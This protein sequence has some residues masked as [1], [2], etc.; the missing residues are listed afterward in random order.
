[1]CNSIMLHCDPNKGV[2]EYEVRFNPQVDSIGSRS[3]YLTQHKETLGVARTFDGVTLFLPKELSTFNLVAKNPADDSDVNIEIIFKRKKRLAEC[4][5]LYNVLFDR[6]FRIL[7]YLRVGRKCFDPTKPQLI[8]QHKLEIWPGYVKS[9]DEMEGG[10][11]LSL[12]VSHRVLAT[13]SVRD[14]MLEAYKSDKG[15]YQENIK[16]A[17]VGK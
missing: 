7:N 11:M 12:D 2:F 14:L 4:I 10:L 1:M 9:V 5:Q 6:I 16:K 15:K 3:K 17:L 13:R 8:P